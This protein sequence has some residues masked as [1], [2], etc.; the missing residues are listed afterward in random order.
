L[1][2]ASRLRYPADMRA[3]LD[4]ARYGGLMKRVLV[5]MAVISMA[6]A[7]RL[8]AGTRP[9]EQ[10]PKADEDAPRLLV[11][12]LKSGTADPAAIG[13]IVRWVL[14]E[15][16]E[17]VAPALAEALKTASPAGDAEAARWNAAASSVITV[18][19]GLLHDAEIHR[20]RD[21]A[22]VLRDLEPAI[23]VAVPAI[24]EAL[25]G[26]TSPERKRE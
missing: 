25:A 20:R 12:A 24:V 8:S 4:G 3:A 1:G 5:V 9:H 19:G 18:F 15:K 22:S 17:N 13:T 14:E 23:K 2:L 11:E 21:G 6:G 16:E 26:P 7:G 10:R